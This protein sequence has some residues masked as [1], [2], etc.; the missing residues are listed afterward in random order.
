MMAGQHQYDMTIHDIFLAK[1][2]PELKSVDR[3]LKDIWGKDLKTKDP[4]ESI[5][6]VLIPDDDK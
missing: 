6:N 1:G 4:Q 3:F 5:A 2:D